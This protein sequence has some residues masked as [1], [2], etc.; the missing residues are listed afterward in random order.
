[1]TFYIILVRV[2]GGNMAKIFIVMILFSSIHAFALD[3]EKYDDYDSIVND[4]STSSSRSS[5]AKESFLDFDSLAI[6]FGFGFNNSTLNLKSTNSSP[7]Q[8]SAQGLQLSMGVDLFSPEYVAEV[9]YT[10]YNPTDKDGYTY[11]LHEYNLK[12][13]YHRRLISFLTGKAGFGIGARDLNIQYSSGEI[14]ETTPIGQL[15]IGGELR[16]GKHLGF[17]SDLSYKTALDN[18]TAQR[19]AFDIAIGV[20]GHF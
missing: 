16:L 9:D 14:K 4:L 3:E 19:S 5:G 15:F 8:V 13:Y 17:L 10:N 1:M 6:H 12:V 2:P 7:S 18:G 20:T 11:K